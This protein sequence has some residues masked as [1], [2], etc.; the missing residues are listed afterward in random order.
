MKWWSIGPWLRQHDPEFR[1][2]GSIVAF[3][4]NIYQTAYK[5]RKN[6]ADIAK[7]GRSNIISIDP[8]TGSHEVAYGGKSDQ[9]F[10]SIVRGKVDLTPQG[11][12]LITEFEA[13]RALEVD[14]EGQLVWEY[15]NRFNEEEV[16]EITEARLYPGEYFNVSDWA[17][18]ADSN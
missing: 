3:N 1:Q 8:A 17:C 2:G 9:Q 15:I 6:A 12:F 5:Q 7:L 14:S 11:G 10:L 16:A 18:P 4:N 13:G